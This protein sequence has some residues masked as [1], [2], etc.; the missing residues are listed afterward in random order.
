MRIF[1]VSMVRDEDDI[2][3]AT[4]THHLALGCEHIL[5]IDNGSTDGTPSALRK[6]AA[7]TGRVSWSVD[8]GPYRQSDLLTGLARDA[9]LRGA[10]WVLPFD[11]DEFWWVP[12]QRLGNLLAGSASGAL[13]ASVR[14]FVQR[15]GQEAFKADDLLTMT[16]RVA[17]PAGPPERCQELVSSGAIGFVEMEYPPK[18]VIRASPDVVVKAGNHGASNLSGPI[19]ATGDIVCLHAPLRSKEHLRKRREHGDRVAEA[20]A[21]GQGWHARRWRTLV[22]DGSDLDREW[23]AN[24][25]DSSGALELGDQRHPLAVDPTLRDVLKATAF[26]KAWTRLRRPLRGLTPGSRRHD[27][28]SDPRRRKGPW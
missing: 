10:D 4:I 27:S 2:I 18:L 1:G 5:V 25:Y 13:E 26:T 11:A 19:D 12:R 23:A 9:T 17:V 14:N 15:R 8:A 24:S 16:R 20:F 7:A 3:G 6:L 22:E 21:P 28:P